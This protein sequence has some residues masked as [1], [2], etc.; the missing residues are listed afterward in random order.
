M[1]EF[2]NKADALGNFAVFGDIIKYWVGS[3]TSG[4]KP[5]YCIFLDYLIR[6]GAKCIKLSTNYEGFTGKFRNIE[7]T[8]FDRVIIMDGNNTD[9]SCIEISEYEL[10]KLVE[11]SKEI[12]MKEG[13]PFV[14]LITGNEEKYQ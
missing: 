7:I 1:K 9:V 8:A 2:N 6:K 13:L 10:N 3:S 14:N 4:L 11:K 5:K 12:K